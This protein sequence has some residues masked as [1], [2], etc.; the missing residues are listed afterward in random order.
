MPSTIELIMQ[1]TDRASGPIGNVIGKL[2]SFGS[3]ATG[4]IGIATGLAAGVAAITSN[5]LK[6]ADALQKMSV[7][8][9]IQTDELGGLQ[10][11]FE[12]ADL[13][14]GDL[15]RTIIE[16]NSRDTNIYDFADEVAELDSLEAKTN[17]VMDV[18][19]DRLGP[20]LLTALT[21][22]SDGLKDYVQAHEDAGLAIDQESA[23]TAAKFNDNM[24][25]IG[26]VVE[27]VGTRIGMAVTNLIAPAIE[28]IGISLGILPDKAKE[29][30]TQML[31]ALTAN[32]QQSRNS[33]S[34]LG[35]AL[36]VGLAAQ[37]ALMIDDVDKAKQE[38]DAS[39]S[40][41]YGDPEKE[42]PALNREELEEF[43]TLFENSNFDS[44]YG[45]NPIARLTGTDLGERLATIIG[46]AIYDE[47]F[48]FV[49]LYH[50]LETALETLIRHTPNASTGAT[51]P[52]LT[53][54]GF[55]AL[56]NLPGLS[57]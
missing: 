24:D 45:V 40:F 36:R 34:T 7:R 41:I 55:N 29:A 9:G 22:G 56:R 26:R 3:V 46:D 27:G 38:I 48:D 18:V 8:T 28:S 21:E 15:Q 25:T 53:P 23:E 6:Q 20:K 47:D 57:P 4:A 32:L 16:L 11:A 52:D 30:R 31:D 54:R 2:G 17:L 50:S 19:G 44:G 10:Y 1:G 35:A 33:G 37:L 5:Y 49:E 12:Q 39:I 13:T 14:A 43:F 42:I 51:S